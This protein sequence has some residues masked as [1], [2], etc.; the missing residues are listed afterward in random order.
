MSSLWTL[1][2]VITAVPDNLHI[3][4]TAT[5]GQTV[6]SGAPGISDFGWI[7]SGYYTD[8][9]SNSFPQPVIKMD[10]VD[11]LSPTYYS[12]GGVP[13]VCMLLDMNTGVLKFRLSEP[14]GTYPYQI[15]V[16]YQGRAPKLIVPTS[17]FA[18]PDNLSRVLHETALWQAYRFAKG[19]TAAESQVQF[20]V[21]MQAIGEALAGD[22]N[23][24][25]GQALVPER[26]LM[27]F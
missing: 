24:T 13:Q 1:G 17:I 5:T 19:I 23:E 18:W 27:S 21:A 9:N 14:Q 22:D 2:W 15:N 3:Q 26:S 6:T 4:F 16:V 25:T 7:E 12:T 10:A 20:K 11:R 8:P